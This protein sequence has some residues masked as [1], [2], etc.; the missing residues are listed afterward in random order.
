MLADTMSIVD[1]FRRKRKAEETTQKKYTLKDL[2]S[3]IE[4]ETKI[5]N[6]K[7]ERLKN[8][9]K[10]MIRQISSEIKQK[11]PKLKELSLDKRKGEDRLK[12]IVTTSLYDYISYLERLVEDLDK[13]EPMET[14]Q[15]I[16]EVQSIFNRFKKNSSMIYERATILIG[17]DLAEVRN[18]IDDF[19]KEFN[20]KLALNKEN[21]E[22]MNFIKTIQDNLNKLEETKETQRQIEEFISDF[23]RKIAKIEEEKGLFE[24]KYEEYQKSDESKKFIEEQKKIEQ[25]NNVINEEIKKFKQTINFKD[26]AKYFHEDKKKNKIIKDYSDNFQNSLKQDSNFN[27]IDILKEANQDISKEKIS[28]LRQKVLEEK[29]LSL[30]KKLR[31]FEEKITKLDHESKYEREELEHEKAKGQK[32][33]EDQRQ[34]LKKIMEESKK[35]WQEIEF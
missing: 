26:L 31:E 1:F 33:E 23:E 15:Y 4:E 13:I 30:D 20:E 12:E 3:L 24:K 6:D 18:V 25:E 17:K 34:I 11:I 32:F 35:I 21:F 8:E 27:I 5:L 19:A 28:E 7:S 16:K 29:I 22:R 2:P 9:L 10:N 14:R